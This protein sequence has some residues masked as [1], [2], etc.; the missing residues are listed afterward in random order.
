SSVLTLREI[1]DMV[2][3]MF[4]GEEKYLPRFT[5]KRPRKIHA[6]GIPEGTRGVEVPLDPA[7]AVANRFGKLFESA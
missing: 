1:R 3:E 7:L 6:V 5:G 4:E 2:I